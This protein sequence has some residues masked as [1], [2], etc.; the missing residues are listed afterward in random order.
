MRKSSSTTSWPVTVIDERK[1]IKRVILGWTIVLAIIFLAA[2]I[3]GVTTTD[4]VGAP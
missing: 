1:R 3:A 4:N 2:C